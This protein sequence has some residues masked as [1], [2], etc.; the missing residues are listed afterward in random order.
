M[1]VKRYLAC[2]WNLQALSKNTP[3]LYFWTLTFPFF[4]TAENTRELVRRQIQALNRLGASGIRV[5]ETHKS[6]SLHIHLVLDK[7]LSVRR[8]RSYWN[9]L[10]GG[11]VHCKIIPLGD[12]GAY[13]TKELMKKSQK[14]GLPKG[15]RI[16]SAF[17][18]VWSTVSKTKVS[19]I[20]TQTDDFFMTIV[21]R[22][23]SRSAAIM[24]NWQIQFFGLDN[25]ADNSVRE[26][27]KGKVLYG[28]E[29]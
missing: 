4:A 1:S 27:H 8:V 10:G 20:T 6:G 21:N 22:Q 3:R 26:K 19:N 17:G 23:R 14:L 29:T 12:Y 7:F 13:I 2:D 15:T 24:F 25:F 18:K 28:N 11:R 16:Y 5:Y 9:D